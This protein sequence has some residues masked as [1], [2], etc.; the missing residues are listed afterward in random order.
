[1][2][3][4]I[5]ELNTLENL[6]HHDHIAQL[7]G[8]EVVFTP[9]SCIWLFLEFCEGGTLGDYV[10]R[11]PQNVAAKRQLTFQLADAVAF[12]HSQHIVHRDLKPQNLMIKDKTSPESPIL[13]V[14][15]FGQATVC[16]RLDPT[17]VHEYFTGSLGGTPYYIAPEALRGHNWTTAV[18]IF[19]MGL[20][21]WAMFDNL[22]AVSNAGQEPYLAPFVKRPSGYPEAIGTVLARGGSVDH[23]V[24]MKNEPKRRNLVFMMIDADYKKRPTADDVFN[25]LKLVEDQNDQNESYQGSGNVD[26]GPN[27]ATS[28][29][30]REPNPC[31]QIFAT[32]FLSLLYCLIQL[33]KAVVLIIIT[34][35]F[36]LAL[37]L[38]LFCAF[39]MSFCYICCNDNKCITYIVKFKMVPPA[40]DYYK[41]ICSR[42]INFQKSF[43]PC[44]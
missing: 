41:N 17:K 12:L 26:T 25:N 33:F 2:D 11:N 5:G 7:I 23:N 42:V 37:I 20:I 16:D 27:V 3:E 22:N 19:S 31:L 35:P 29:N 14:V 38:L 32:I 18:D 10:F 8:H 9:P 43:P 30:E 39:F 36:V 6:K 28:Q 21:V 44:K 34:I 4:A 13:K 40:F 24:V 1:M 15:D